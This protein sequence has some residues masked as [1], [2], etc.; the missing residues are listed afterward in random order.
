MTQYVGVSLSHQ[1]CLWEVPGLNLGFFTG[2]C[3]MFCSFSQSILGYSGIILYFRLQPPSF[4]SLPT[5]HL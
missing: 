2:H 5:L 4:K 3:D 1:P